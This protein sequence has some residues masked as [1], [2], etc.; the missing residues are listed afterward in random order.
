MNEL[1]GQT[2][3]GYRIVS[4][5]GQGGMATVY[6]AYQPS[7]DRYVALKV[8][9][10]YL[11]EQDESFAIRFEREAKSIAK[12]RHPNI[13]MVHDSGEHQGIN[14]IVLEY[15]DAGT[16]KE[17]LSSRPDFTQAATLLSQVAKA[18]DYA[19]EQK[20]IHRDVKP[21]NILLPKTDWA[22]LTDFGLATMVGGSFLT[23]SGMTVG[24]P[25]YISPEQ[26]RGEKVGKE[27][28]IYSLGVILYELATGAVPFTAET[29]MAVVIKHMLEPLPM[30]S[31]KNPNITE[32]LER[33]ILKA[34]AKEPENRFS[35]SGDLAAALEEFL[36]TTDS[37]PTMART[38][39]VAVIAASEAATEVDNQGLPI[40]PLPSTV[41]AINAKPAKQKKP[42]RYWPL[43]GALG[44]LFVIGAALLLT[45]VI[46]IDD[47]NFIG[48]PLETRSL[49]QIQTDTDPNLANGDFGTVIDDL[50]S[51]L[52]QDPTNQEIALDLAKAYYTN[53]DFDQADDAI[54]DALAINPDEAWVQE[55][56]GW[57]YLEMEDYE[58][59][60]TH[61]EMAIAKGGDE[62]SAKQGLAGAY[63]GLGQSDIAIEILEDSLNGYGEDDPFVYENL[64]LQYLEMGEYK[65]AEDAFRTAL[66]IEP[67]FFSSWW[68]LAEVY[69]FQDDLPGAISI[70][71]EGLEENPDSHELNESLGW[72][73][74]DNG[75]NNQAI[76]AFE[77]AIELDPDLSM[78]YAILADLYYEMGQT[79][80]AFTFLE[81]ALQKFPDQS[82]LFE[83]MGLLHQNSGDE[84][85]S[86]SFFKT[87]IDLDPHNSWAKISL[88]WAYLNTGQ[89]EGVEDLLNNAVKNSGQD[90]WIFEAVGE[91]YFELNDC[92]TAI[93]YFNQALD[94]EPFMEEA[95]QGIDSCQD[96]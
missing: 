26:G 76:G 22:L 59:A 80:R 55:S 91:I 57:H 17:F 2:L 67:E 54:Q 6:K 60:I 74:L 64:G 81:D 63:Q 68:N 12:L 94:L 53:G 90:P 69:K 32:P 79:D 44:G 47:L 33:I 88:A 45:G 30:P 20:V 40:N 86:I 56:A 29:P 41:E 62:S 87:A 58:K 43:L 8:L 89:S 75:E 9:P 7:L 31:S 27:S 21:S 25:A 61:F 24:T 65:K 96:S 77:R 85:K 38:P 50:I 15:V 13:L 46:P 51:A 39:G 28:D 82:L 19:H 1:I 48:Q 16:Y 4:Q 14:Y 95:Q 35:R 71:E 11:S 93:E 42:V 92:G 66:E 52:E 34:M 5:I 84:K 3:G 78:P 83:A 72:M 73:Y 10:S 37:F 70:I 23:Q 49:E 18:L 36:K